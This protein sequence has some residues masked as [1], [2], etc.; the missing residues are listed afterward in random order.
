MS[1]ANVTSAEELDAILENLTS[2]VPH[3]VNPYMVLRQEFAKFFSYSAPSSA[4]PLLVLGSALLAIVSILFL[5][6]FLMRARRGTL[7]AFRVVRV[8]RESYIL[9][10]LVL[11][12]GGFDAITSMTLQIFVWLAYRGNEGE[13]VK[14]RILAFVLP[15]LPGGVA[16]AFAIW[17]LSV[18]Y[19]LHLRTYSSEMAR[20]PWYLS[21]KLANTVGI[22]LPFILLG[23]TL[24]LTLMASINYDRGTE[25]Y[26][27]FDTLLAQAQLEWRRGNPVAS[28]VLNKGSSILYLSLNDFKDATTW[29]EYT[30]YCLTAW[31]AAFTLGFLVVGWLYTV[32]LQKTI[33]ELSPTSVGYEAFKKT[34][35]WLLNISFMFVITMA[36]VTAHSAWISVYCS[37][38][39]SDGLLYEL[40]TILPVFTIAVLGLPVSILLLLHACYTPTSPSSVGLTTRPSPVTTTL[41]KSASTTELTRHYTQVQFSLAA[42]LPLPNRPFLG[43][44]TKGQ[45]ENDDAPF[46]SLELTS[47]NSSMTAKEGISIKRDKEVT[48]VTLPK[49][50]QGDW[51][52]DTEEL[53][54][55]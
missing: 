31:C 38:M 37:K 34:R 47:R 44:V 45:A 49:T 5:A 16:A 43:L 18:T 9:G 11:N 50:D 41:S 19:I 13:I 25:N 53:E 7:W 12:K 28:E 29:F 23:S 48:V 26:I 55:W 46:D 42:Q 15:W 3:N 36:A 51:M 30:Y 10:S 52:E 1:I 39:L 27:A 14:H 22:A 6:G 4:N 32:A 8:G 17:C 54:K 24:P 20:V 21:S 33:N 35:R 40:A 2:I